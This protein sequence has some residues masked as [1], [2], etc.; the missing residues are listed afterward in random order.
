MTSRQKLTVAILAMANGVVILILAALVL[1]PFDAGDSPLPT[2]VLWPA[3]AQ[4]GQQEDCRWEAAQ[5][6]AQAGLGGTVALTPD[7]LLR[8]EIAHSL[9]PGETIGEATQLVWLAFDVALALQ[10]RACEFTWVEIAILAR[11]DQS[12]TLISASVS[13]E[14]LVAFGAGELSEDEFIE[15]VI[16][17]TSQSP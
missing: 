4:A 14:D 10:E 11:R 13:A 3:G 15:R 6:L 5:M 9:Q 8:L 7:D 2:S 1:R 12:D 16:Y 17:T